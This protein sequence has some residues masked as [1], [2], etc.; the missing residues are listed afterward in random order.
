MFVVE[1]NQNNICSGDRIVLLAKEMIVNDAMKSDR[2]CSGD[3]K[4][5]KSPFKN[6]TTETSSGSFHFSVECHN[7]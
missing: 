5:K 2:V 6:P 1:K 3:A 7:G 4:F